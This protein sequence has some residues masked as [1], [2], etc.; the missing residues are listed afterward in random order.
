[1]AGW[2]LS[3]ALEEGCDESIAFGPNGAGYETF[4]RR[5]RFA[6][7]IPIWSD[8]KLLQTVHR[9]TRC[10]DDDIVSELE[11]F[12][13]A[14]TVISSLFWSF[15]LRRPAVCFPIEKTSRV[16]NHQLFRRRGRHR[17][18][19]QLIVIR[20][21]RHHREAGTDDYSPIRCPSS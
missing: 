5:P 8:R 7:S 15:R 16:K 4:L 3:S 11:V 1:M 19:L 6:P 12:I 14:L 9:D 18:R 10:Y 20:S 17:G 13:Y 21:C 2:N